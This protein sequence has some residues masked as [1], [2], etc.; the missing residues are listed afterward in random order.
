MEISH[1]KIHLKV[2]PKFYYVSDIHLEMRTR[3][4]IAIIEQIIGHRITD[5]DANN[6][7]CLAGDIGEPGGFFYDF[8]LQ[9]MRRNFAAVFV[10]AGNHE[11]YQRDGQTATVAD[12]N[13]KMTEVCREN[14]VHLLAAGDN[15]SVPSVVSI[16]VGEALLTRVIGCTLWTFPS[17]D[18]ATYMNDYKRI[19]FGDG[20]LLTVDNVVYGMHLPQREFLRDILASNDKSNIVVITHHLPSMQLLGHD[21]VTQNKPPTVH[22]R[23]ADESYAVDLEHMIRPPIVAWICGHT[24]RSLSMHINDVY[25]GINCYG[26]P[27][28]TPADTNFS[29]SYFKIIGHSLAFGS[30]EVQ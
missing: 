8:F 11:Y 5:E 16:Y 27:T 20:G 6:I 21:T 4:P 26:Y 2:A 17:A 12:V 15:G 13:R 29:P 28:Q 25:C 9:S 7:L 1:S 3:P 24:H 10:V 19:Y 22:R 23:L 18:A 14:R 30:L